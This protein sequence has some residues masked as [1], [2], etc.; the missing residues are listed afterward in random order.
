MFHKE[1]IKKTF[2]V[3]VIF[4]FALALLVSLKVIMLKT[5]LRPKYKPYVKKIEKRIV[6]GR[7]GDIYSIDGKIIS[8]TAITYNAYWDSYTDY[9]RLNPA[10]VDTNLYALADS[11]ANFFHTTPDKVYKKLK[12]VRNKHLRAWHFA[13]NLSI[14]QKERIQ[15]FPIFKKGRIKGGLI[16]VP[17]KRRIHPLGILASRTIGEYWIKDGQFRNYG[18]EYFYNA[19]L[20]GKAG[21]MAFRIGPK[22]TTVI[23]KV[24]VPPVNGMDI[25]STLDM[26]IQYFLE[27]ALLKRLKELKAERGVG[28]VMD[29]KSGEIR[30]MAN[31]LRNPKDSSYNEYFNS[32]V[33]WLYEPGSVMKAFSMLAL[34]EEYPDI[35][36]SMPVNTGN[37]ILRVVDHVFHDAKKGGYGLLTL[38]GVVEHSS[39]VGVVKV[40][41]KYFKDKP[42]VFTDHLSDIGVDKKT[43]IDLYGE[44][45]QPL[46]NPE[47]GPWWG[48]VSLGQIA[49]GY[50]HSV[51]PI[52]VLALYNAIANNGIYVTPHL[53]RSFIENGKEK[54]NTVI[55]I[56]KR[57]IASSQ[58]LR[59]V[60]KM[61]EGVVLRGTAQSTVKSDIIPIA[62]KTG[63]AQIYTEDSGYI[64]EYNTTFVGYF[65]ADNP[66]YSMIIVIVNPY[67][68]R[69]GALA[70]GPVFKEVAEK[71]Y[72]YDTDLHDQKKYIVNYMPKSQDLPR[73]KNGLRTPIEYLINYYGISYTDLSKRAPWIKVITKSD[74]LQLLPY[75]FKKDQPHKTVTL[76]PMDAVYIFSN[77][78]KNVILD[79][80]GTVASEEYIN[81]S[82][83]KLHLK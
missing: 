68:D 52:Q 82:T 33:Q 67:K 36:L 27:T 37:G 51:T 14:A 5:V 23:E 17:V 40:I 83:V 6:H 73:V 13:S 56:K 29:V 75:V 28:I 8:T 20:T 69:S 10:F 48:D 12:I 26:N 55:T 31:L 50:E 49:I 24:I 53:V 63:T 59:K 1:D 4:F 35:P 65:P 22:K 70:A 32:A 43:G 45:T 3:L 79:G 58:A 77:L 74:N 57:S 72:Q 71:I 81:K 39:N 7:R 62:G 16:L 21:L 46:K 30:A 2:G 61:L 47:H 11:L 54:S 42:K 41:L 34:F 25:R 44:K 19:Q 15:K 78:N 18:L 64:K 60:K 66:K 9:M 76:S 80:V 38:Q